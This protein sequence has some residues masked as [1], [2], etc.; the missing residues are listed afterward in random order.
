M[1][2]QIRF[3]RRRE[4]MELLGLSHTTIY[5][6]VEEGRFPRPLR[7][8]PNTTRWRSDQVDAWMKE[9]MEAAESA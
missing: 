4:V 7:I 8:G 5:K 3:M 9:Q 6:M 2:N 1:D